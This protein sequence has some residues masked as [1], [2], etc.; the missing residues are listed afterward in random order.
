M[1]RVLI[2]FSLIVSSNF[3]AQQKKNITSTE[4]K[5]V[6]TQPYLSEFPLLL[7]ILN[8]SIPLLIPQKKEG[9]FGFINQKKEI[10]IPHK[11][12]NAGFFYEDCNL[13][14]SP[15]KK[16]Q[17]F[18]T[19]RFASVR[20][21]NVD[22]RIDMYGNLVYQFKNEDLGKCISTFKTQRYY[23]YIMNGFYGIIDKN[24]FKNETDASQFQIYPQYQYLHIMEGDDIHNPMIIAT[25]N[26]FFGVIDK[27]N[28]IIIPFDYQDIKRNFSWK[29]GRLFEVTK[30]GKN[31]YFIDINNQKY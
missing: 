4:Q 6:I 11:F 28:N 3:F 27:F 29:I 24:T 5:A 30:D 15:N 21:G 10:V 22:Y 1:Y 19:N 16:V 20:L 14:N 9:L 23:S 7:P 13:M 8:D 17:E 31:Y 12:K 26:D 25:H 2:T 18:G